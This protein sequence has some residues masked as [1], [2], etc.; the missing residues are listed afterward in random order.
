[1]FCQKRENKARDLVILFIQGEVF[2]INQVDFGIRKI[3]S[4]ASAP[5]EMNEGSFRPQTTKVGGLC[6]RSHACH[7]G[8]AATF[9]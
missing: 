6:S 3:R 1:M 4:K 2:G 8:Y 9:V 7:T 5:A